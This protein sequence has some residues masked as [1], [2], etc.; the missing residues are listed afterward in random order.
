MRKLIYLFLVASIF[1]SCTNKDSNQQ[2][3]NEETVR[4]VEIM[5]VDQMKYVVET[6]AEKIG[7]SGTL[8]TSDGESYLLL[9]NIEANPGETLRIRLTAISKLP[10]TQMSHN[11]ILLQPDVD[12][13]AFAKEAITAKA[14]NYIPENRTEDIIARTALA[15]GGDTV[16]VTFTVPEEPGEYDYLCSF[17]GHFSGGMSGKLIVQ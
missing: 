9:D 14:R 11:W 17:P 10:P 13:K 1:L 6:D 8:K 7:T 4:T 5:G 2:D 15:S 12:P 3:T 16:E